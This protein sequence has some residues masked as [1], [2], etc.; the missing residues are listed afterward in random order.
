MKHGVDPGA[1]AREVCH[2]TWVTRGSTLFTPQCQHNVT[3]CVIP[4]GYL[5]LIISAFSAHA[6][7]LSFGRNVRALLTTGLNFN[8]IRS[9]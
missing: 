2:W 4:M 5:C 6:S 9:L 7:L 8:K 3:A 1:K